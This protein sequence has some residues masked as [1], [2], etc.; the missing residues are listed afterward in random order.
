MA[1]I[2]LGNFGQTAAGTGPLVQFQ[3]GDPIGAAAER[4]GQIA[5]GVAADAAEREMRAHEEQVREEQRQ[6]KEAQ[7]AA[8][9][10]K[11]ITA[12][13]GGKNALANL[14]DEITQGVIDGTVEKDK[15]ESSYS[16][17]AR[18][19]VDDIGHDLPPEHL[20]IVQ[21]ELGGNAATLGN[22]VRRAV[23]Q[24]DRLDVTA[25]ISQTLE[26]LQR[27]YRE[28]PA[29]ATQQ[30]MQTLDQL[31][32]FST[33]NP[34]Q[35]QRAK[36]TWKE[37]TQ[38]TQAFEMVSAAKQS[39]KLLDAAQ[40]AIDALPDLDPQKRAALTDRIDNYREGIQR[41]ADAARERSL[42][43]QDARERKAVAMTAQAA[44]LALQGTLSAD[45]VDAL[46]AGTRGTSSAPSV[47]QLLARQRETGALAIQ[48]LA[49]QQAAL[50]A[51]RADIARNGT[52]PEREHAL[53]KVTA[54]VNASEAEAEKDDVRAYL[55][56]AGQGRTIEPLDF[57]GGVQGMTS[58]LAGRAKL[59][60][61]VAQFT[62]KPS[63]GL[64]PEE[65]AQAVK[66][67]QALAPRDRSVAVAA[68]AGALGAKAAQGLAAHVEK[69]D[70]TLGL[71]FAY[72]SDMTTAGRHTSELIAR[73]AQAMKDGTS[74]KG[75]K[76]PDLKAAQ[77]QA[78]I[79]AQLEG[80]YPTQAL[81][82][83]T[84][85]AATLIMHAIASEQG[86]KLTQ[87]DMER[88]VRLATNSGALVERG[89]PLWRPD[90]KGGRALLPL[91]AGMDEDMLD[92]RLQAITPADLN[93]GPR[94]I[95]GG[96]PMPTA[97][98]VKSLPGQSLMFAAPGRY[99]VIVG[100]R[101]VLNEQGRPVI[102]RMQ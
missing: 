30:A 21:A 53:R 63:S 23:T 20:A 54:V 90:G 38:Y 56:R 46:I 98:F 45:Y 48:P 62:G 33:L 60:Q 3:R 87:D 29:K 14:S 37:G 27:L 26:Y 44:D 2:P 67:L 72:A 102:V 35:V 80:V 79:A 16:E 9:R 74:T 17:R 69:Q 47:Q 39:P 101:P 71:E 78:N 91:P 18:K 58:Q 12:L 1:Q 52:S 65:E 68:I 32:P 49:Q 7:Q 83:K 5:F 61:D 86:G 50:D 85:E 15:A 19:I 51:V 77:W 55:A 8:L 92:K 70:K 81:A 95:A 10:A 57:G 22:G 88:A 73:G 66:S 93:A 75:E 43:E 13:T 36:Q 97:D 100:G 96:V 28:N 41:R 82:D 4:T 31:G 84:R 99:V 24:R 11:T 42:R 89:P 25:G 64:L 59:A 6:A 40:G 76:Q 34:E 94:V